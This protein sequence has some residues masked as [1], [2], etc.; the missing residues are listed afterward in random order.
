MELTMQGRK[1][2][3]PAAA[4]ARA[5][6][7]QVNHNKE[8]I[9][10]IDPD[11]NRQV[12]DSFELAA[13]A[14]DVNGDVEPDRL[15]DSEAST[16]NTS[17]TPIDA[18][19]CLH[20]TTQYQWPDWAVA[21]LARSGLS[22]AEVEEQGW[23]PINDNTRTGQFADQD[24]VGAALAVS[25]GYVIP[26]YEPTTGLPLLSPDGRPYVRAKL[27]PDKQA[28]RKHPKY[29]SMK[30]AGQHAFISPETH[31]FLADNTGAIATLVEGEKKA[32]RGTQAGFYMIGLVG[33][34]GWNKPG[35]SEL[36]PEL[37]VYTD[38]KKWLLIFDSDGKENPDF[39]RSANKLAE[40]LR[41]FDVQLE[42]VYLPELPELSKVGVDDFLQQS[43]TEELCNYIE[44]NKVAVGP[45]EYDWPDIN[46]PQLPPLEDFPIEALPKKIRNVVEEIARCFQVPLDFP[47]FAILAAAGGAMG[48]RIR[49][50]VKKGVTARGNLYLVIFMAPGE[51]KSCVFS[52]VLKPFH[53]F[54]EAHA[55]EWTKAQRE[56]R[57]HSDRVAR[58]EKKLAEPDLDEKKRLG[59]EEQLRFL[60][61]AAPAAACPNLIMT[62]TT[63]EAMCKRMPES[64]ERVLVFT[65]EGRDTLQILEGIYNKNGTENRDALYLKAYDGDPMT[66][67]RVDRHIQLK[68]PSITLCICTQLDRL[69]LLGNNR[70][71]AESGFLSRTMMVLPESMVG[72]RFFNE[73]V[74]SPDA[75]RAYI[76]LILGLLED[77]ISQQEDRELVLDPDAKNLWVAFHDEI[78]VQLKGE[79]A[80]MQYTA[81]RWPN[82][83][84]RLALIIAVIEK[85]E[86][87]TLED[88]ARAI[89]L[90]HRFMQHAQRAQQ[91]VS[92]TLEPKLQRVVDYICKHK[93]REFSAAKL[94]HAMH[95]DKGCSEKILAALE[96]IG[97]IRFSHRPKGANVSSVYVAN[98]MIWADS[99]EQEVNK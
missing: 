62:N 40:T 46:K 93:M 82:H 16:D 38:H 59:Y 5:R 4:R 81:I 57:V 10:D 76:D 14:P 25:D 85:H 86:T 39:E 63:E 95:L 71:L 42:L 31:R 49:V 60:E 58:L 44:E 51:R 61:G 99:S 2:K 65:G 7:R 92:R 18:Q 73:D 91:F 12:F 64:D 87:I 27:R 33:N 48:R 78:E 34:H 66:I 17:I 19:E 68:S 54:A 74:I 28:D 79:F 1:R 41:T 90:E 88:M 47:A 69:T 70:G 26:F 37:E 24:A 94:A 43:S 11:S 15:P 83:A 22:P 35:T 8:N 30:G 80:D 53:H 84:L 13:I 56:Q 67:D 45:G 23:Y 55:E 6:G 29:L 21:D 77:S 9:P 20:E 52:V 32:L 75:E 96:T 97:Y 98:P 3:R 50:S 89:D 36:L 72:G